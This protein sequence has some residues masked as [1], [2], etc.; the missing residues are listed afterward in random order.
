VTSRRAATPE[1]ELPANHGTS[2]VI[3]L[4]EAIRRLVAPGMT[5]HLCWSDA[6]PNAAVAELIRQFAGRD[7]RFVI[8][9]V[10]FANTQAA[11]VA[12][13]LVRRL[14]TAYAGESYPAG[15]V[16]ALF[17]RAIDAGDVEI[18]NWSQ[19][20]FVQRLM[21]GA[22]GLPFMPTRSLAGSGLA[23]EHRG[24]GHAEIVDPFSGAAVGVVAPLVPDIA[25]L[26]GVA[27]D[28]FGNVVM[29]PPYGESHWGGLAARGGVIAC[30]ERIVDTEVLRRLGP[31]VRMPGHVVRAV[32]HVPFGS[33]PYGSCTPP[34][35]PGIPS[36]VED[37]RFISAAAEAC[38]S[39]EAMRGW[40]G[41]WVLGLADHSAYLDRLGRS[42]LEALVAGA[43]PEAWRDEAPP[44]PPESH[45]AEE[46]MIV[47]AGRRIAERV[48]ACGH[49][50]VLAGIGASNIASWLAERKLTGTGVDAALISEIGIYGYAPRPGEPFVFSLRNIATARCLTDVSMTLGTLASGAHNRCLGALG[51]AVVDAAGNIGTTYDQAGGFVVGSGG[52]NDIASA[53]AEVLVT[54]KHGRSRLVGRT[55]Y[56]TSPGRAVRTIV[57]TRAVLT[58]GGSDEPFRIAAVLAPETLGIDEAIAAA[59]ADCGWPLEVAAN[60]IREPPPKAEEL[61]LI[62]AF[63]PARIFLGRAKPAT[64]S[65]AQA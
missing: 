10:G 56:V 55:R 53:A 21:A 41:E 42:R 15:G 4:S 40:I 11:L 59:V 36:Y 35:L 65:G 31:L 9:S 18:E 16:N 23:E 43:A 19:W 29:S 13:G 39:A 7:P 61:A 60:V 24:T 26:Q 3:A 37:A 17:K 1:F 6:R 62:R 57:T 46:A 45:T 30:V 22:L 51:A 38:R 47:T 12:A 14:V 20:S 63:D 5:L 25:I 27:A 52:G 34:G 54:V 2:K 50:T 28:P 64:G 44:E 48:R 8:T 33:H 58:R 32:C 49:D